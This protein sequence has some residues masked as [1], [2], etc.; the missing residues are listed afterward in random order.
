[1]FTWPAKLIV[2]AL[3]VEYVREF[4]A[5]KS[6]VVWLVH[7]ILVIVWAEVRAVQILFKLCDE[8]LAA[9]AGTSRS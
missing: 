9:M 3:C 4:V 8:E 6:E 5:F 7:Q 2:G 1:M